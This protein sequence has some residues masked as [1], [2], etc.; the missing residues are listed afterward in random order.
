M[1]NWMPVSLLYR[2]TLNLIL[3]FTTAQ[4]MYLENT[5]GIRETK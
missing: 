3:T 2:N 4:E 5:T 1:L